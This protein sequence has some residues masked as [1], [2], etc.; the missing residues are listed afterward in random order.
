MNTTRF[1]PPP[2]AVMSV[3]VNVDDIVGPKPLVGAADAQ[4]EALL[5]ILRE[6]RG[7]HRDALCAVASEASRF[8]GWLN[9]R[10]LNEA[11]GLADDVEDS[12]LVA[13]AY[14]LKGNIAWMSLPIGHVNLNLGRHRS[15][16]EHLR[17]GL[18]SLPPEHRY[19]LWTREARDA[20]EEAENGKQGGSWGSTGW[21]VV[22]LV[23]RGVAARA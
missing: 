21:R 3:T 10:F 4:R 2:S 20:L 19:A 17:T 15:A 11:V 6:A 7:A 8:T 1:A 22:A 9:I 18:D 14:N 12:A 13:Q 23:V 16:A 5:H